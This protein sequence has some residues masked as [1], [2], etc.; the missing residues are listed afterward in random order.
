ME[1]D[2]RISPGFT[3]PEEL[4]YVEL[5]DGGDGSEGTDVRSGQDVS[6][7]PKGRRR[8]R[9]F[10]VWTCIIAMAVL[11]GAFWLRYVNPYVVGS[12]ERG[13]IVALE[14]RGMIFKTWEGEMITRKAMTDTVNVYS[15]TMMFSV[16]DP[17][18]ASRLEE[19]SGIGRQVTVTFDRYM[20]TLPWR[21]SQTCI[22]TAVEPAG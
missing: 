10:I 19:Y 16:D 17:K 12:H 21:G 22:V 2:G 11:A 8:F 4:D 5:P 20:G 7:R 9:R 3:D 15:G 13:Y 1:N 18:V 6:V 14:Y